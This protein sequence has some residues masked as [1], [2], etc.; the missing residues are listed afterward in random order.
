MEANATIAALPTTARAYFNWEVP[1]V[2]A[3]REVFLIQAISFNC[4]E[5][6]GYITCSEGIG[7]KE[8]VLVGIDD[9]YGGIDIEGVTLGLIEEVSD[10]IEETTGIIE[11]EGVIFGGGGI[12]WP[13]VFVEKVVRIKIV[14]IRIVVWY[15][16]FEIS[17]SQRRLIV[18]QN[19]MDVLINQQLLVMVILQNG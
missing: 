12:T 3:V 7:E 15:N 10:G 4:G 17:I 18:R 13:I 19:N 14:F 11:V 8:A 2:G 6:S 16:M 5:I 9:P 1:S